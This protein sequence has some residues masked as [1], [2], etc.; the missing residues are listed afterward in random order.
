MN[1]VLCA[2]QKFPSV[3]VYSLQR[4]SSTTPSEYNREQHSILI[5]MIKAQD[6]KGVEEVINKDE[7]YEALDGV[8]R[9]LRRTE[10]FTLEDYENVLD[11]YKDRKL[12]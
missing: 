1:N 11:L 6:W 9:C 10:E 3:F 5:E 12:S 7:Y 8:V 2:I 4:R